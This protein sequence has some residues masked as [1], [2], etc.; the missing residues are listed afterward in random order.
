MTRAVA[1]GAQ[2]AWSAGVLSMI[3]L[4]IQCSLSLKVGFALE[5]LL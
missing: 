5:F 3:G 4:P 2:A 1:I